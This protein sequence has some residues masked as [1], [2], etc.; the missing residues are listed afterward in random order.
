MFSTL[1]ESHLTEKQLG[2]VLKLISPGVSQLVRP[3]V[4]NGGRFLVWDSL[5]LAYAFP[6]VVGTT[7]YKPRFRPHSA[8]TLGKAQ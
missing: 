4:N 3:S 6:T 2:I 1:N 5:S 8:Y 7:N